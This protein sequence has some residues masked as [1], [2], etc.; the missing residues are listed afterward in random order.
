MLTTALTQQ[1]IADQLRDAVLTVL[2]LDLPKDAITL[3]TNLH[4][5]GL[6]SMNVVE[7]L[8][9]ME[10]RFDITIDVEDLSATLFSRF[11]NLVDFVQRKSDEAR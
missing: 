9:E 1:D 8:A 10:A 5:L 6:E 2:Q 4:D 3:E 7:L 11:G